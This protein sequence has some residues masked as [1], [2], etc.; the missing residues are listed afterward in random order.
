VLAVAFALDD[1]LLA[2]TPVDEVA[3]R[4]AEE[5]GMDVGRSL[6]AQGLH[7]QPGALH[8]VR[9][10][11]ALGVPLAVLSGEPEAAARR[12]AELAWFGGAVVCAEHDASGVPEP[13]AFAA[14]CERLGL[15]A[16]CIWYVTGR[17]ERDA[18]AARAC[19]LNAVFVDPSAPD[20][21]PSVNEPDGERSGMHRVRRID[22]VLELLRGPYTRSA[23]NMRYIMRTAL[24]WD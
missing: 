5:G 24:S 23:L 19:E 3:R 4:F 20:D 14:L 8:V 21:D 12:K 1:T 7:P 13:A 18:F 17:S 6:D 9:E 2:A 10:L 16:A 11:E 22:D 15:P